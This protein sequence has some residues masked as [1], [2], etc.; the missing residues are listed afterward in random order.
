MDL[1]A[2]RLRLSKFFRFQAN[3][4]DAYVEAAKEEADPA[5]QTHL[6]HPAHIHHRKVH[7][8]QYNTESVTMPRKKP[9]PNPK[10]KDSTLPT[11]VRTLMTKAEEIAK[12]DDFR[13]L[14]EALD[15]KEQMRTNDAAVKAAKKA[16]QNAYLTQNERRRLE[17]DLMHAEQEASRCRQECNEN[18]KHEGFLRT[19]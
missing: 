4:N 15:F 18:F 1:V 14:P 19:C 6:R 16:L 3:A 17:G 7:S 12:T 11:T 8:T 13:L 9:Y 2:V 5:A 10:F